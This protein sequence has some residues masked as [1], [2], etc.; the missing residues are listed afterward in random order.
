ML[1]SWAVKP[2]NETDGNGETLEESHSRFVFECQPLGGIPSPPPPAPPPP[3]DDS[4]DNLDWV[5]DFAATAKIAFGK[6]LDDATLQKAL[7][8]IKV[9]GDFSIKVGRC[10]LT[11]SN[12]QLKARQDGARNQHLNLKN[13]EPLS[14]IAFNF[15]VRRYIKEGEFTM[16]QL[17]IRA[18]VDFVV[19]AK[20]GSWQE[21]QSLNELEIT[22]F[23]VLT[24]PCRSMVV[25]PS[26]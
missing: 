16:D 19:P 18:A 13:N 24:Y 21:G 3:I 5:G 17:D 7:G 20:A 1:T 22:G 26:E 9:K 10:R 25:G 8:I 4:L 6:D 2:C 11:V 14:N 12:P 23:A 15:N